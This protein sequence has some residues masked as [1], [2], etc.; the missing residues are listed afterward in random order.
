LRFGP[1]L[2]VAQ[3]FES[4]LHGVD[5]LDGFA[6]LLEQAVVSTAENLGEE[7]DGHVN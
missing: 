4:N 6:V 3:A 1:Q 7:W 2:S 5:A